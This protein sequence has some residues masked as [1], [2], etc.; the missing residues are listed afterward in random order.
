MSEK[1]K[2]ATVVEQADAIMEYGARRIA[3]LVEEAD[4]R[5]CPEPL[6][7]PS[8]TPMDHRP[9]ALPV[10]SRRLSDAAWLCAR[11]PGF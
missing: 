10:A 9:P 5:S 1:T 4:R 7:S 6:K 3:E 11:P 2:A 8:T